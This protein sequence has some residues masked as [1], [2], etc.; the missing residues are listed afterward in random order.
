M[1]VILKRLLMRFAVRSL[2]QRSSKRYFKTSLPSLSSC[3][4]NRQF[5]SMGT[6]SSTYTNVDK[7]Q[8][9]EIVNKYEDSGRSGSGYVIMDVREESEI[10]ATGKVSQNTQTLPL[11]VL[12][13][14]L[15]LDAEAFETA[16]GF[17]KPST[18]ETLVFSCKSG[19]R[20]VRACSAAAQAGYT[21]IVNYTGGANEWFA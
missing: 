11:S 3:I 9:T 14:S 18:E 19:G 4:S 7:A 6:G 13:A 21:R 10:A 1:N 12:G 16:R 2:L 15:E 20:S 5:F 17:P 8:M